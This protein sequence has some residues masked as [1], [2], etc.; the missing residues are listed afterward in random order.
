LLLNLFS[1]LEKK[2]KVEKKKVEDHNQD[3]L[4]VPDSN[5]L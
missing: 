2:T 5:N 4:L 3:I 1:A